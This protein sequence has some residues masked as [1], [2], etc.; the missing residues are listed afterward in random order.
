MVIHFINPVP[1]HVTNIS[2]SERYSKIRINYPMIN[3]AK[4][5]VNFYR[6]QDNKTL[7][8]LFKKNNQLEKKNFIISPNYIDSIKIVIYTPPLDVA[9]GGIMVLHNLAKTINNF[10]QDNIKAYLYSYDHKIYSND[11]CNN[12][13]NPFLI[14]NN[15][16]VIYPENIVGNPLNAKHVVRWV[17]LDLG[18]DMPKEFYKY[19]WSPTDIVYNW[20]PSFFTNSKRLVNIWTNPII[21]NKQIKKRDNNCYAFKKMQWIPKTLNNRKIENY[22]NSK[23]INIDKISISEAVDVFN[24]SKL[25]YCYDPNTFFSIMAPLCGCITV[26]YPLNNLKKEEYF[27]SRILYHPSGFSYNAGIA[28]GNDPLEIEQAQETVTESWDQYNTICRLYQSTVLDFIKDMV[29]K[30]NNKE[31]TNTV[32]NV[33]Y[34]NQV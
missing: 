4:F 34:N 14:D 31:L 33:Y 16:I 7:L 9:C 25:F 18:Y 3:Q 27:K 21:K 24:N 10:Q 26:L 20:E 30:L 8:D 23:D 22:H 1:D 32:Q 29:D 28:Y 11:F 19:A 15:T 17:L 2:G 13:I 6:R 5:D 12:F